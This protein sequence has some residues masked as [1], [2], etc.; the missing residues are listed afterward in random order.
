MRWLLLVSFS[1]LFAGAVAGDQIY[2]CVD[3][4]GNVEYSNVTCK[5]VVFDPTKGKGSVT[6]IE[7]PKAGSAPSAMS[8]T[9]VLT[10]E[11]KAQLD[12]LGIKPGGPQLKSPIIPDSWLK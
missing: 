8:N 4:K 5:G 6:N 1:T 2:K 9:P 3:A 7:M 10:P 11:Q 12:E